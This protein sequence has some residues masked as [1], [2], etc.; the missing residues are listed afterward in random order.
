MLR[1]LIKHRETLLVAILGLV[2]MVGLNTMMLQYNEELWTSRKLGYWSAFWNHFEVSG[3]DP[4]TY[5][6]IS[7][8]RPLYVLSRHPLLAL[9]MWPLS[10]LNEWLT[11]ETGMNCA[12][13]IVAVMMTV[14][15]MSSWMLMYRIQRKILEL[16]A[17]T[18]LLL[19][20]FFFSFSHVMLILFVED[21]MAFTLPLLLLTIY[22]AGKAIKRGRMMP[23]WQSLPLLFISTGVT[24]T[25]CVKIGLA[26]LFTRWGKQSFLR[27][28]GHFLVY[29][30]PLSI[31]A[32]A[33]FY[34]EENSQE[35]ERRNIERTVAR[36]I[37]RDSTF[38]EK[39][40]SQ[41]EYMANVKKKQLVKLSFVTNTDYKIDR[42]PSLTENIFGEGLI[43]H[44]DYLLKDANKNHRPV[45]VR[46]RHW[47]YYAA[48]VC[49][50]IL[51]LAGIWAGR[52]E[53]LLWV[54][55]SMFLMDMVLHVGL[56]F[57]SADVY[58][59]TAHWAFVIPIA[60]GYLL[61]GLS[62]HITQQPDPAASTKPQLKIGRGSM[63][64]S[65]GSLLIIIYA[66]LVILT[67]FLWFHN[68][69]LIAKHILG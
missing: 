62:K 31:I 14:L 18:S 16:S 61:K 19:T 54:V 37:A 17:W 5:I 52:K 55:M 63:P 39:W 12:I 48:E 2:I 51:F 20:L 56:N 35:T 46:Y 66:S 32:G 7:A 47:W 53:R 22:L 33:Y 15:S 13:Y 24:T 26:D 59:M 29:L 49:I 21:H 42:L 4:Y 34:Q 23:L 10:E 41:Q 9:M 1:K 36:R 44:E 65:H 67:I 8:W 38:A 60:I 40:K 64:L 27:M 50:V 30:I 3:F 6:V 11:H 68:L 57:A 25:N 69:T 43:L 45:L 28:A 58:I